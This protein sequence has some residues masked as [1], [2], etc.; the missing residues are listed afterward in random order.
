MYFDDCRATIHYSVPKEHLAALQGQKYDWTCYK[1]GVSNF[2][3]REECFKCGTGRE[4]SDANDTGDEI[5]PTPT[6]CE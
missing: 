3:R 1:C 2:K 5:S 6:N 4:E